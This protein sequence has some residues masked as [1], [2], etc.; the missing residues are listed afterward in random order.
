MA[1]CR[2][3][4]PPGAGDIFAACFLVRYQQTGDPVA[5]AYGPNYRRLQQIK[6]K[7]DPDN[8]FHGALNI[9]PRP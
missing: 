1:G 4:V 2:L 9:V 8:L 5:A 6:A 7:Y 3:L